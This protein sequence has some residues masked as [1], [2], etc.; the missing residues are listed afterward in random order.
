MNLILDICLREIQREKVP[1]T[2]VQILR[3]IEAILD[4]K[5]FQTYPYKLDD[6]RQTINELIMYEEESVGG[7]SIKEKECIARLNLKFQIIN[8]NN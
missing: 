1:N 2:R 4:N 7:Y 6:I 8:F 5:K 3:A